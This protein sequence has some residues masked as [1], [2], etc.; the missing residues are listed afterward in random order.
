MSG[1]FGRIVDFYERWL[2][3]ALEHPAVGWS[4]CGVLIVVSYVCLPVPRASDLLP[5]MDEGGFILDYFTPAGSSLAGD[6]PHDLHIEQIY[7]ATARGGKH[8]TAHRPATWTGGSNGSQTGR[9]FGEA[10]SK[11]QA[12]ALMKSSPTFAHEIKQKSP[13]LDVEFIR[14]CRT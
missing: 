11:P 5:E 7:A 4:A 14:S 1:F 13:R 2:R 8:F 3:C 12:A 10:E 9:H 6:G